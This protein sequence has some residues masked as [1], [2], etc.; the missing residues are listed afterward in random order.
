MGRT[1]EEEVGLRRYLARQ[2][3]LIIT[4]ADGLRGAARTG[5]VQ[6]KMEALQQEVLARR[7]A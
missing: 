2:V 1:R 3:V 7:A 6:Q 5:F 4:E